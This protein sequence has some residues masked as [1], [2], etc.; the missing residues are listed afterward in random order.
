MVCSDFDGVQFHIFTSPDKTSVSLSLQWMCA[1]Q[2]LKNGGQEELE[3]IYGT[4]LVAPEEKFHVTLSLNLE[5]LPSDQTARGRKLMLS[6]QC[7]IL[8]W[9]WLGVE[10][11]AWG[12]GGKR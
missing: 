8:C 6:V 5:A 3:K 1:D 4:Y 12:G 2:L 11:V 9:W 7:C 10:G